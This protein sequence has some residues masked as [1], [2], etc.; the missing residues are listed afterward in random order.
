LIACYDEPLRSSE[1]PPVVRAWVALSVGL[2]LLLLAAL[3]AR[4]QGQATSTYTVITAQ[5]KKPLTTRTVNGVEVVG[6]DQLAPVFE[7]TATEDPVVGG[8]TINAKGQRIL[9]IPGQNFAQ[10][11]GSVVSLSGPIGR[12]RNGMYQ[13]PLDFIPVALARALNTRI[14]V[15]RPSKLIIVGNVVVP[16]VAIQVQKLATGARVTFELQPTAPHKVAREGKTVTV[17]FDAAALD[18]APT[19]G[20]ATEFVGAVHVQGTTITLDL[21]PQT[22]VVNNEDD[23]DQTHLT[24]ELLPAPPP[25]PPPAAPGAPAPGA[26]AAGAAPGRQDQPLPD[27]SRLTGLRTIVIDPGHGGDDAGAQSPG[28][29]KEK[30]LTLQVARRLRAGIEGRMGLRVLMTREA[31]DNVPADKRTAFANNNKADL[32]ISLH[33]NASLAPALRG[34]Q[35]YTLSLEDY[36]GREQA[37]PRGTPVPIVGGGTRTIDVVPWDLAQLPYA[38]RS[39]TLGAILVRHFAEHGVPLNPQPAV[40]APLRLLVGANMPAALVEMGFLTNTEDDKGLAGNVS[41]AIVESILATIAE[42]RGGFPPTAVT[43]GPVK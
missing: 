28:G 2:T 17:H 33:A 26:P 27:L 6:L 38:D 25:P 29:T 1:V 41:G 13:V 36:K 16:H 22:S 37:I 32:L 7:L 35:V 34:A 19:T 9:L 4:L 21:G 18:M 14:E 12:D 11:N 24:V 15:R 23:R 40:Q 31:D 30:D 20:Q 5:N 8:L 3:P 42:L 10:V 39:A 43:P